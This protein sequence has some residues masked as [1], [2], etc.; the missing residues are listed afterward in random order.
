MGMYATL[1]VP[2]TGTVTTI[3]L[4]QLITGRMSSRTVT[5]K[6]VSTNAPSGSVARTVILVVPISSQGVLSLRIPLAG[7]TA[8]G[9]TSPVLVLAVTV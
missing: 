3:S 6:V 4:A 9:V 1:A 7:L 8:T 5:M 2:P